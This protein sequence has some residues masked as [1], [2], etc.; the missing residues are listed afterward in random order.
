MPRPDPHRPREGQDALFSAPPA[1]K[2]SV[3]LDQGRHSTAFRASLNAASE[4]GLITDVDGALASSLMAA[5]WSL[6]SFEAQ[7]KPYGSSKLLTPIVEALREA[8]MTPDSRQT[9]TEDH[10]AQLVAD[11]ADAEEAERE[12]AK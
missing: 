5:A 3:R 2:D 6:D 1:N 11:L 8:K 12:D 10:I 7:N 4:Q 9:E